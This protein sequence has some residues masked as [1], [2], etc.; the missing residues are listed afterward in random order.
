M[1]EQAPKQPYITPIKLKELQ[2]LGYLSFTTLNTQ[3]AV[4]CATCP[5]GE[6]TPFSAKRA[7]R[8]GR[9]P[10]RALNKTTIDL[11]KT[12]FLTNRRNIS[13]ESSTGL[14]VVYDVNPAAKEVLGDPPNVPGLP[15]CCNQ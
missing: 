13:L 10:A 6:G 15:G 1:T 14:T 8:C 5:F 3:L 7:I 12:R 4:S 9:L 11:Y 2:N